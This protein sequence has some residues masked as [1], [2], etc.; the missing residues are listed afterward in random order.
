[1]AT[2]VHDGMTIDHT[3]SN[4]VAA[5][6]V[7]VV[8]ALVGVAPRAIAANALGAIQ[9]EGVFDFPKTTSAAIDAGDAV[10]WDADPGQIVKTQTTGDVLCGHAVAGAL[11]AAT[12]VRVK[13]GR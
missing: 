9:V 7:V 3:P 6:D 4:A 2:Y 13:L 1:M 5:G 12:T 10:Y 8:G 11:E